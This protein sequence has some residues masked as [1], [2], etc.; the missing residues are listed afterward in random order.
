MSE[1]KLG[2]SGLSASSANSFS[3]KTSEELFQRSKE[4]VPGGVHSPVRSFKGLGR[5]PVFLKRL[6]VHIYGALKVENI[7]IFVK[8]LVH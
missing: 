6:K 1:V 2:S 3:G 7:S 5:G 8:V 4:V